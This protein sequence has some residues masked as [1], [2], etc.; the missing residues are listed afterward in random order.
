MS[1]A[2]FILSYY[3]KNPCRDIP[4]S[5]VVDWA[6]IEFP[7]KFGVKLRD[8]DRAIRKL[9][10]KGFLIKVKK[11]VYK[12][13]PK[14]QILRELEDFSESDKN[15]ILERDGYKCARCNRPQTSICI[16]QVDHNVPKDLGGKAIIEN[17]QAICPSCNFE[18]KN[19]NPIQFTKIS[20]TRYRAY[21][22]K[23]GDNTNIEFFDAIFKVY[24]DFGK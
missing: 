18:K 22:V 20:F 9:A 11:G 23:I 17:G 12:F 2:D 8:P 4:H 15:I 14:V 3:K 5:E 10:Q 7:K 21:L 6:T 16:L 1:Q 24:A 13:D 19:K